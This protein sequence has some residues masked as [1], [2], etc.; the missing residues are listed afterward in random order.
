M[1]KP[2]KKIKI[3]FKLETEKDLTNQ[4]H[5][6]K[7]YIEKN[8]LSHF[9]LNFMNQTQAKDHLS[10]F[11]DHKLQPEEIIGKTNIAKKIVSTIKSQLQ[12]TSPKFAEVQ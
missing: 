11:I 10:Y 9:I 7:K 2:Q 5:L 1:A 4:V 8:D 3:G 12:L 6:A